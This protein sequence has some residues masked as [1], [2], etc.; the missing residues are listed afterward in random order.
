MTT[1]DR[2][3]HGFK[4]YLLQGDEHVATTVVDT[5]NLDA[6]SRLQIY[7]SAYRARLTEVLAGD[8]PVLRATLGEVPFTD[9]S[10]AY[11][12]THPS[13]SFTLRGFGARMADFLASQSDRPNVEFCVELAKFEWA[14]VEAF[15]SV[16][17]AAAKIEDMA[18]VAPGAWPGLRMFAHPSVQVVSTHFNTPR[19]WRAV[20]ANE[21]VP[22]M[23]RLL[24]TRACFVWRQGLKT[25]FRSTEPDELIAWRAMASGNDFSQICEALLDE[26]PP[27][28]IPARAATLLRNWLGE[29]LIGALSAP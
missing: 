22:E 25:V 2:L 4:R 29:G 8:Y 26:I 15:D 20:K 12:A 16:D 21:S 27:D 13:T 3:Q 1:L 11:I 23:V 18:A 17:R 19:I 7:A 9:L 28:E 6:R 5:A 10:A 14:F 24:D